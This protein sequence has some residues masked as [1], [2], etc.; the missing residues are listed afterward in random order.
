MASPSLGTC[1]EAEVL[2]N[3]L[4]PRFVGKGP[5]SL[6]GESVFVLFVAHRGTT[7]VPSSQSR[8]P[9]RTAGRWRRSLRRRSARRS[10]DGKPH[11]FGSLRNGRWGVCERAEPACS[12]KRKRVILRGADSAYPE[13]CSGHWLLCY[14]PPSPQSPSAA[15]RHR[16]RKAPAR[17]PW[18]CR[19]APS[20]I[21]HRGAWRDLNVPES[22]GRLLYDL[23]L[24]NRFTRAL[25]IGTLDRPLG[26]L[27]CLGAQQD[28]RPPHHHRNRS[29]GGIAKRWRTSRKRASPPTWTHVSATRTA[30][31]PALEGPFDFVFSDADKEWYTN[32]FT[33]VWPKMAPGGC[34]TAHNV[35]SARQRGIREFLEHLKTVPRRDDH[36]R[37]D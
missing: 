27:D 22:D 7:H 32:Y 14:S 4:V 30:I 28:R 19:F 33:A 15:A 26:H 25:E 3:A 17:V 23:I 12:A 11:V 9:R 18:I 37:Q 6:C 35:G 10:P 16:T 29:S 34:F 24:K 20:S 2:G 8:R 21:E 36:D 5:H 31:V 13:I 1:I